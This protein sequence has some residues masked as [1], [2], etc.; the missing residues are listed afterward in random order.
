MSSATSI[1]PI[2]LPQ[3]L[4]RE[5]DRAA[6]TEA[7]TRSEFVR[8]LLRRELSFLKLNRLQQRVS[9]LAPR[10]GIQSLDDAVRIV[11]DIRMKAPKK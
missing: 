10:A 11:R 9:A 6:R 1:I 3:A 8:N 5:L 7:M 4:A 2:S